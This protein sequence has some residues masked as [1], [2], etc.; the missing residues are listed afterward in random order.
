MM[1]ICSLKFQHL[2]VP[3]KVELR[4]FSIDTE[5]DNIRSITIITRAWQM[6]PVRLLQI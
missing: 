2:Q 3:R 5:F 6:V 4:W 1:V